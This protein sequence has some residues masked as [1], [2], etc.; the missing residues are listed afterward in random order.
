MMESQARLLAAP[1]LRYALSYT[2][3][4]P[5]CPGARKP[6][7]NLCE[8]LAQPVLLDLGEAALQIVTSIELKVYFR[9]FGGT[10]TPPGAVV[11]SGGE[12]TS[13]LRF[14]VVRN[15]GFSRGRV[16]PT[17]NGWYAE[18]QSSTESFDTS[19]WGAVRF[20]QLDELRQ[21]TNIQDPDNLGYRCCSSPTLITEV[22]VNGYPASPSP[23]L[24]PSLTPYALSCSA[25][26]P[27]PPTASFG[28]SSWTGAS[29]TRRTRTQPQ[30]LTRARASTPHP[31][32]LT[33]A[34]SLTPAPTLTPNPLTL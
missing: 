4:E 19:H 31:L 8:A 32:T 5:P 22:V 7:V 15:S 33:P 27:S 26:S 20:V 23:P 10:S 1:N 16:A 17:G 13:D 3:L 9:Y 6:A 29:L 21:L 30:T 2:R 11:F 18:F 24:P 25:P 12:N 34:P 14:N 28:T